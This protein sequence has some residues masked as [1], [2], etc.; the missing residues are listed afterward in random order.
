MKKLL[1]VLG[2]SVGLLFS[3]VLSANADTLMPNPMTG[4]FDEYTEQLSKYT[5]IRNY[6]VNKVQ[7]D[8]DATE[9]FA[10]KNP[11]SV[12]VYVFKNDIYDG[13]GKL[14]KTLDLQITITDWNK[15]KKDYK[16]VEGNS[17]IIVQNSEKRYK[18]EELISLDEDE[19]ITAKK[20]PILKKK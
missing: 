20:K 10:K 6:S 7:F 8:K 14:L 18:V 12:K 5:D 19:K 17:Y 2:L 11:N 3:G 13:Y 1:T 4:Q 15:F 16:P 9:K